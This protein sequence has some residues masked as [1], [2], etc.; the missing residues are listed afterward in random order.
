MGRGTVIAIASPRSGEGK[1]MI[2]LAVLGALRARGVSVRAAKS[3]PDYI[4]PQFLTAATGLPCLTLDSWAMSPD[5]IRTL[6]R[7]P[8]D[9]LVLEGAMGLFDGALD[10]ADPH[11]RGS[12][13]DLALALGAPVALVL[14]VARQTQ[15]AAA[16]AKG[17]SEFRR[18]IDIRGVILNRVGSPRHRRSVERASKRA[19]CGDRRNSETRR[20]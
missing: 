15:T 11:G 19:E 13:A 7:V 16:V 18:G 8:E 6:A 1:T 5:R 2:T 3:G 10:A 17:L 20:V 14:D 9:L 12:A 4:D